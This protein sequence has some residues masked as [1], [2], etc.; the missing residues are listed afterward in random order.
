MTQ[1]IHIIVKE[2]EHSEFRA[3]A[4]RAGQSLSEWLRQAGRE[5]LESSRPAKIASPED[6]T[7][8]FAECDRRESGVEPDWD[9]HLA[10]ASRSRQDGI[11]AT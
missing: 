4:T 3:G 11:E 1:R 6:L 2:R 5:R 9:E 7:A 8:F 10:V